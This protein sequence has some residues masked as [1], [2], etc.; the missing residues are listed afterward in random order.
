MVLLSSILS[1]KTPT[2]TLWLVSWLYIHIREKTSAFI[3]VFWS[4]WCVGSGYDLFSPFHWLWRPSQ[5][6]GG[7]LTITHQPHSL[8]PLSDNALSCYRLTTI[9][10]IPGTWPCQ[11]KVDFWMTLQILRY[12]RCYWKEAESLFN[13]SLSPEFPTTA[14]LA[15]S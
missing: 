12:L 15:P 13:V 6:A 11:N 10:N 5:G 4:G 7:S 9:P 14:M 1:K 8:I 2:F 3:T